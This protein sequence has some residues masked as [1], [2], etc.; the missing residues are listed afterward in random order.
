MIRSL[1]ERPQPG[2]GV[3]HGSFGLRY[4]GGWS[5]RRALK[6]ERKRL[7]AAIKAAESLGEVEQLKQALEEVE[8]QLADD[9]RNGHR[10]LF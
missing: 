1:F 7:R 3:R 5:H 8:A 10:R 6:A 2:M 4:G 9:K